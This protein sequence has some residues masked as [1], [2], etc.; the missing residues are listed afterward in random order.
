MIAHA[1]DEVVPPSQH[2]ADIPADLECVIL[3]CLAKK[4][5]D[6]FPDVESLEQAL[7][8][9]AAADRWTQRDATHWWQENDPAAVTA[10]EPG[11]AATA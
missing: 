2:H 9:C 11:V 1:R 7:A 4:P 10:E 6:R 3:R 8:D 5:E